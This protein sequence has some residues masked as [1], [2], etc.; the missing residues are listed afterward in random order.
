M[1]KDDN[2]AKAKIEALEE[3]IERIQEEAAEAENVT[4]DTQEYE[5]DV[6]ETESACE[7]LKCNETQMQREIEEMKVHVSVKQSNLDETRARSEKVNADLNIH[8]EKISERMR[9][10]QQRVSVIEKK[11]VKVEQAE[12]AH[13][14][15][16]RKLEEDVEK[17]G[18]A[19]YKAQKLIYQGQD[20][21]RKRENVDTLK[22]EEPRLEDDEKDTEIRS[23]EPVSSDK[24]RNYWE[25]RI[26]RGEK[27]IE[28]E[29]QRRQMSEVDPEVA[30]EKYQRAEKD[31]DETMK[32]VQ[33]IKDNEEVLIQDL[34]ERKDRWKAF[35]SESMINSFCDFRCHNFRLTH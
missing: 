22:D 13:T 11:R 7:E 34:K 3:S 4:F 27:K 32:Q 26:K 16:E 28:A 14:E 24:A 10:L 12:H 31:L 5:D 25:Q 35:R 8:S 2:N 17:A 29:R 1:K 18:E 19:K 20:T 23:I 21:L 6:K 33:V 15:F 30:L 9:S